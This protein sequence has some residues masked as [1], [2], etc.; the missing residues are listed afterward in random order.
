MGVVRAEGVVG[1][2]HTEGVVRADGLVGVSGPHAVRVPD[3][4]GRPAERASGRRADRR[5]S[6]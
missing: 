4:S 5:T 2:V 1:V 3:G 6:G